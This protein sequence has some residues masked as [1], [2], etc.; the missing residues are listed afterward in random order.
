[1]NGPSWTAGRVDGGLTFDGTANYT[2]AAHTGAFN[3]YPL[4]VAA[5]MKT[6]STTGIR[7][8]VNKYLGGIG[9]WLEPVPEQRKHLRLVSARPIE[10]PV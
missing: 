1:M 7:G 2:S 10:L 9:E 6:S 8:I 5:W 4:T 3:A